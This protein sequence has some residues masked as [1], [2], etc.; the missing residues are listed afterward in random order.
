MNEGWEMMRKR[1]ERKASKFVKKFIEMVGC[2]I[3][4][5]K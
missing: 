4:I 1:K 5:K 2:T 3:Q